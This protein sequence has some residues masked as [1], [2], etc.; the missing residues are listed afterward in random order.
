MERKDTGGDEDTLLFR[1][2]V[3]EVRP[4]THDL[5]DAAPPRPKPIPQQRLLDEREVLREMASGLFDGAEIETGEELV[6]FRPGLQHSVVRKLRRGQYAVEAEL[7]LHG[8]TVV[9]ARAA[10]AAFI[11]D[12][13]AHGRRCVRIV[14]GKGHGSHGRQPVL[15]GKVNNW[16]RRID[17][18]LAFCST[19]PAHGGTGAVY[20]LLKRPND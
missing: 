12:A 2:M 4:L 13:Q 17:A 11:H 18:V 14:H 8:Y 19:R 9:E 5:A 16:L 15:K 7:D 10:L 3:G 6:Y 1:Q 20:V